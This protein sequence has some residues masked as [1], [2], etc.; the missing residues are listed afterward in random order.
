MRQWAE[1][2]LTWMGFKELKK[3]LA[4]TDFYTAP[5][6]AHYHGCKEGGLIQHSRT[7]SNVLAQLTGAMHLEW[8]N[9]R[10]P[11]LIGLL[12]DVCKIGLYVPSDDG[13]YT[14]SRRDMDL[15]GLLSVQIL[16]QHGVILT[17]EERICIHYHMGEWTKDGD[18]TYSEALKQCPNL[19]WVHT[20]DMYA[21]HI[22]GR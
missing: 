12:H 4:T 3:W 22:L 5:A 7:V 8:S 1:E 18:M 2:Q 9:F 15:Q 11:Y 17:D 21:S 19:L 20:A 6:S 16:E 14:Y 13:T 10:S